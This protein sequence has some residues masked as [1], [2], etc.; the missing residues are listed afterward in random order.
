MAI[1]LGAMFVVL[2]IAIAGQA[3]TG[4]GLTDAVSGLDQLGSFIL[5]THD[6]RELRAGLGAV[7]LGLHALPAGRDATGSRVFWWTVLGLSLAAGWVEML[8]LLV[9][10][11]ATEGGAVDT[12]NTLLSGTP[13]AALAMLA[14]GI[15]TV[16]VNAMND[17]T[18]SLSLQAAGIRVPRI[19]LGAHRRGPGL[20]RD[21]LARTPENLVGK[22]E[23]ILLFLAYWIAPWAAVVLADWR[24]RGGRADVEPARELLR[25]A[26]RLAGAG[27]GDHRVRRVAAVPD[28]DAGRR[29]RG[30]TPGCRSTRSRR[31]TCTTPTWRTSSGSSSRS[32]STGSARER[33]SVGGRRRTPTRDRL[34]IADCRRRAPAIGRGACLSGWSARAVPAG[35][36]RPARGRA[37]RRG[38]RSPR[39]SRSTGRRSPGPARSAARGPTARDARPDTNGWFVSMNRPPSSTSA[40]SSSVQR[41]RTSA[42]LEI[43]PEPV[44]PGR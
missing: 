29:D 27:G 32:P 20:P 44:I 35:G 25:A 24:M 40:S 18:G 10:D 39:R 9:A 17:Y 38:R 15:G 13:F 23:N 26:E 37:S 3:G 33:R 4:I 21:A 1:V 6:H 5:F 22:I 16:A 19:V 41:A 28:L 30:R 12:I 11:K 43:T 36:G 34:I 31:T 42:G 2:T 7:R 14:I 8:G